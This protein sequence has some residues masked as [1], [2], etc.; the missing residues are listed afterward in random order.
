MTCLLF[1]KCLAISP[2][3][4]GVIGSML[5]EKIS[6][7]AFERNGFEKIGWNLAARPHSAGARL[8]KDAI[9]PERI[10]R[11]ECRRFLLIDEWDVF[12]AR[13]RQIQSVG[14]EIRNRRPNR[15]LEETAQNRLLPHDEQSM[16]SAPLYRGPYI[17]V[18]IF[19]ANT[20]R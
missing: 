10:V 16:E 14:H 15:L 4:G 6:T 19:S 11:I 3:F 5:P 18:L 13:D 20:S 17:Q 9:I 8:L 2:Y 1:G 12:R 7:G